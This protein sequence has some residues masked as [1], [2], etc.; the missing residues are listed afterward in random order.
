VGGGAG[1]EDA[2]VGDG[3]GGGGGHGDFQGLYGELWM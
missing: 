3:V 2:L 1:E